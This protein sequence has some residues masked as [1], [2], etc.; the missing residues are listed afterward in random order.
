MALL[1]LN[2]CDFYCNISS[3]AVR[4]SQKLLT[5]YSGKPV[6]T[7]AP[8]LGGYYLSRTN[9]YVKYRINQYEVKPLTS[10]AQ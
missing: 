9:D 4:C 3:N 7:P 10:L 8:A 6:G 1:Y 2:H 5:H